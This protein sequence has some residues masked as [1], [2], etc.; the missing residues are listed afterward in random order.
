MTTPPEKSDRRPKNSTSIS[1]KD[2]HSIFFKQFYFSSTHFMA[3]RMQFWQPRRIVSASKPKKITQFPKKNFKKNY[4]FRWKYF[5][6]KCYFGLRRTK[7]F[8]RPRQKLLPGSRKIFAQF[9]KKKKKNIFFQ[10]NILAENVAR[11]T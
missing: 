2:K 11:D 3:N 4:V 5:P 6:S 9:Q 8:W 10:L 1:G 7:R